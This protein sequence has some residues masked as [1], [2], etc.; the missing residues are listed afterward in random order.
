M[1]WILGLLALVPAALSAALGFYAQRLLFRLADL[2]KAH[3]RLQGDYHTAQMALAAAGTRLW[4]LD[5]TV[6]A[7]AGLIASLGETVAQ[8]DRDLAEV[9]KALEF[10]R[11]EHH[12]LL[13]A[14][15]AHRDKKGHN[16][17]HVPNDN[18]LYAAAG[19]SPVDRQLPDAYEFLTHCIRY[20]KEESEKTPLPVVDSGPRSWVPASVFDD[21]V[22]RRVDCDDLGRIV[23]G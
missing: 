10:N 8:R 13:A 11:G 4:E 1:E 17:C 16:A 9:C 12:R 22:V 2:A 15:V 6:E 20:H 21:P 18:E 7:R 5:E 3:A 14:I 19:L 23:G